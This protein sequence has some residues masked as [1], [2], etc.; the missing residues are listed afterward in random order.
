VTGL[1][2]ATSYTFTVHA[3]N[4]VGNSAESAASNAITPGTPPTPPAISVSD[5]KVTEANSAST[6]AFTVSLSTAATGPVSVNY[7]TS[8]STATAP[9]DYTATA[10]TLSFAVGEQTKT[11]PVPVT[12]DRLYETT[13][14]FFLKLSN[15]S[16]ATI[17]NDRG[18]AAIRNDDPAPSITIAD[19]AK[20]E[21]NSFTSGLVFTVTLS[22][23]SGAVTNVDFAT[24]NGTALAGN[25][26]TAISGTVSIPA[27]ATSRSFSVVI[28]GDLLVEPSETL[29]VN[30]TNSANATIADAQAVGTIVNDD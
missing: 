13:E 3:T 10:G 7:A 25:D 21:G 18:A 27:G 22:T 24:A 6:A 17:A 1:S 23:A 28:N 2:S 19:A 26:Y 15:A 29:F 5:V 16:G 30:F 9:G 12:G 20:A 4:A 8:D 14:K 11:V